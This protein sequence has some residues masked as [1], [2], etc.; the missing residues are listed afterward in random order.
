MT[1]KHKWGNFRAAL[2]NDPN[3]HTVAAAVVHRPP[4]SATPG[5]SLAALAAVI[6][7]GAPP[8]F[9]DA[10]QYAL[11]SKLPFHISKSL[12]PSDLAEFIQDLSVR[13]G[14]SRHEN[15][16]T[17]HAPATCRLYVRSSYVNLRFGRHRDCR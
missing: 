1:L 17:P 9:S 6:M 3:R 15:C 5:A 7:S 2:V 16:N 14:D 11:T 4:V 13:G 8:A 12:T 10:R